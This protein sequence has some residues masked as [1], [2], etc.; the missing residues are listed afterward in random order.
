MS[1]TIILTAPFPGWA[2][3]LDEVPDA[4][5]AQR[6][7]G[8]GVALDPVGDCLHAPCDGV[9]LTIHDSR[10]AL[11]MRGEGGIELLI[12][13]GIE[14]VALGGTPFTPL[15]QPGDVVERG[16][17]LI[18][19]DLDRIA[20][21]A[22]SAVTP[23]IV[24]NADRFA[25][26]RTETG[27]MLGMGEA[28]LF[29]KA[30]AEP[31]RIA[32]DDGGELVSDPFPLP[33]VH[34]LHA[35]P[36]ARIG[37][38]ARAFLSECWLEKD[39]L[40]ASCRSVIELMGL[41]V[42]MGDPVRVRASGPDADAAVRALTDLIGGGMGE[43]AT[44]GASHP[45]VS[46]PAP[47]LPVAARDGVIPGVP[48]APGLCIGTAQW[49]RVRD[50][51]IHEAGAGEAIERQRLATGLAALGDRL[52]AATASNP[53]AAAHREMLGDPALMAA[54]EPVIA[55]GGSAEHGWRTA[56]RVM[57]TRLR[58]MGDRR[59][60]ERADDYLDLER[61]MIALLMGTEPESHTFPPN[62]ILIADDLLPSQVAALDDAVVGLAVRGSGPTAH[63]AVIAANRG[64]PAL[65]AIG[66]GIDAIGDGDRLILDA[67]NGA[68]EHRPHG[69]RWAEA[70]ADAERRASLRAAAAQQGRALAVTRDGQH[71]E[72]F[73][74]L[75]SVD[76]ARAATDAG[77]EGCGL[78]RT[79]F[80]FLDR[81]S[82]PDR[83]E[84]AALYRAIAAAMP[85]RPVIV[86]LLDI[87][88]DKPASYVDLPVEENPALGLR[89]IRV[90]LAHPELLSEQIAGIVAATADHD[91]R[92]MV[93]M[94]AHLDEL[95]AVRELVDAQRR[96]QGIGRTIPV[97]IMVETPAAAMTAAQLGT[98]ADFF[99]IGT[100]DLTQYTLAMDRG[101][102]AIAGRIDGLHPAVLALIAATVRG[103][104]HH[105]RFV[106]LC[107]GLA[108][109]PMAVP[110]LIGLGVD[111][112]SCSPRLVPE[113]KAL[114][115]RLS[116]AGCR[117]LADAALA[118]A[119]PAE[120]RALATAFHKEL[121]E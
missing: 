37:E 80:L 121:G 16:Q 105:G 38:A 94:V 41:G 106:G 30:K 119:S 14:T 110:I 11:T 25:V 75:G 69:A 42:R 77:A 96:V 3:P 103:A 92:I 84:Q 21:G 47:A 7:M 89:G 1:D 57:A 12:H 10:H 113:V 86:R 76:D 100:N 78:L 67:G 120:V 35:R 83:H 48:A 79:E 62:T 18:G 91:L 68:I 115:R 64:L 13:I 55:A 31:L 61:Q 82:P 52:I 97:G 102:P 28:V 114:I 39:D 6:M 17:P 50:A 53:V 27:R 24:T 29:L 60:A 59:M 90:G 112:L 26:V 33:M 49:L 107:G 73:A 108:G 54:A 101:N 88:G 9:V 4:V 40:R 56:C 46:E 111:E 72:V 32:A 22:A 66:D 95:M 85:G 87:G 98:A 8:D 118:A 2:T 117:T 19:F 20:L 116:V 36:S 74:N 43:T 5:F 45:V 99:S 58:A 70:S 81:A 44:D 109:D 63:I 34:G 15:V 23:M 65:V 104:A 51:M 93:P 71:V